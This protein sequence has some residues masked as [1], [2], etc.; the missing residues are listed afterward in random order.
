MKQGEIWYADLSPT[1]G[2]QQAGFRPVVI[3]SGNLLNQYLNVVITC[4]LT[5][6][7]KGY[8]GNVVLQ[9]DK[10]NKLTQSSEILVFHIRSIA[11]ERLVRKIGGITFDQL[12]QVKQGLDEMLRY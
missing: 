9:P 2:S 11:K 7:V 6:K 4:P 5:T 12:R 3:I 1:K 8:K 10:I